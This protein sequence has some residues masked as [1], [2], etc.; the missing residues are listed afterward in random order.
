MAAANAAGTVSDEAFKDPSFRSITWDER[1]ESYKEQ[2]VVR[3]TAV[4]TTTTTTATNTTN[5]SDEAEDN[6]DEDEVEEQVEEDE[7]GDKG[8]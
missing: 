1:V 5:D 7:P 6:V 8:D 4:V 2:A 3:L